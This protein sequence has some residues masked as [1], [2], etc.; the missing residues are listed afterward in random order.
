MPT[1]RRRGAPYSAGQIRAAQQRNAQERARFDDLAQRRRRTLLTGRGAFGPG[2]AE[3]HSHITMA[4][5]EK[6]DRV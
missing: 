1:K 3:D 4:P 6:G 5:T 2:Y